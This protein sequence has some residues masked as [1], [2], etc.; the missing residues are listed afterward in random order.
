MQDATIGDDLD[1]RKLVAALWG[2]RW[3]LLGTTLAF[4]LTAVAWSLLLTPVFRAEALVQVRDE[5]KPGGGGLTAVAAQ[6]G[7]L[8][9]LIGGFD[10]GEKDKALTL[11]TLKSRTLIQQFIRDERLMPVLFADKWDAETNDWSDPEEAP[12][13]W[14]G[15]RLFVEEVLRVG[16]DKK[17]GLV[18]I[19]VE[20]KDAQ[21]AADWVTALV[22][23]TNA[24]LR[25]KAVQESEKNL[26]YLQQQLRH[27]G[28]VELQQSVY[29]LVES[30]MKKLMLAKGNEE[31]AIRTIDPAQPPQRKAKPNRGLMAVAGLFLGAF[32]GLVILFIRSELRPRYQA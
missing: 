16:E 24:Y 7:G 6:L 14:H 2:G 18:T 13:L 22:A 3:I 23:R 15:H 1:L 27:T 20:W 19:A 25:E 21:A 32:A 4:T 10:G 5:T 9:E 12:S 8:A 28:Q 17:T 30:E 31:Y 11:A 26:A 29:A